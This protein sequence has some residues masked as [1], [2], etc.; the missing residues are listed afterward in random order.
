LLPDHVNSHCMDIIP[1]GRGEP[2][3]HPTIHPP[4]TTHHRRGTPCSHENQ[5]SVDGLDPADASM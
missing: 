1:G 4:P 3:G 2:E 5:S